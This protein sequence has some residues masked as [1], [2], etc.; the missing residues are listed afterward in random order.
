MQAR[1]RKPTEMAS[2][3]KAAKD[4]HTSRAPLVNALKVHSGKLAK[5]IQQKS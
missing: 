3:R 1:M 4:Q 5:I 2:I